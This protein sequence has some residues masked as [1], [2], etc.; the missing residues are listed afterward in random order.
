MKTPDRLIDRF[1]I[2]HPNFGIPHLINYILAGNIFIYILDLFSNGA[3]TQLLGLDISSV[4]YGLQI[5]RPFTF[6]FV[7]ES[8]RPLWFIVSIFFYYFLGNT[9]EQSWGTPKFTLFYLT[10]A[11]LTI[12]ADL[13]TFFWTGGASYILILSAVHDTLFLAFA[14]LYPDAPLRLYF[15]LP[16]KAKWLAAFYVF[17][18]VWNL[19]SING[20]LLPIILP[21]ILPAL[22]ASWINYLLFFWSDISGFFRNAQAQRR[23]Q[24]SPQTINFKRAQQE[25]Q[26][27]K[28][29]LHKCSVCGITDQDA[30]DMDFRYCSKCNGYYCYCANHINNHTH[31]Q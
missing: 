23:H 1:A 21:V 11:L 19:L 14:T 5:W 27:R 8:S 31:I 4:V 22:L 10:G 7:P 28:G 13:V 17:M 18:Q 12:L 24:T 6:V 26:Q 16:I 9:M 15:I 2:K 29:Y 20:L 25:I 3:A 30:P